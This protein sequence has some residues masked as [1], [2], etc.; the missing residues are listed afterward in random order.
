M[1]EPE[2]AKNPN[3]TTSTKGYYTWAEKR[4]LRDFR[5]RLQRKGSFY[6]GLSWFS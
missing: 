5:P 2:S 6:P 1:T 3:K 4:P